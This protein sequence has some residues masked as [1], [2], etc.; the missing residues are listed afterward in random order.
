MSCSWQNQE[1]AKVNI[2]ILTETAKKCG[3]DINKDKSYAIIYNMKQQPEEIENI[4]AVDKIKYF[5]ITIDNKIKMFSMYTEGT[6]E[7]ES[8]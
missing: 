1:D 4:K 2:R 7:R 6:D 8:T 5:G 3:L